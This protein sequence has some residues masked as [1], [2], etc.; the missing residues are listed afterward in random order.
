MAIHVMVSSAIEKLTM[1]ATSACVMRRTNSTMVRSVLALSGWS[2]AL[3]TSAGAAI[4]LGCRRL[5]RAKTAEL[6]GAT[7]FSRAIH[8]R[9]SKKWTFYRRP[10]FDSALSDKLQEALIKPERQI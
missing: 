7:Q 2:G 1:M 10:P 4:K 6:L 3:I 5:R 9:S 8:L